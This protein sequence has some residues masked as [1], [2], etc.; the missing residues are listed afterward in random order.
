MSDT[1]HS[2]LDVFHKAFITNRLG[3]EVSELL[4]G[5]KVPRAPQI[6]DGASGTYR[7]LLIATR[8]EWLY[9]RLKELLH[10][11][12]I[13][14]LQFLSGEI[15]T[16]QHKRVTEHNG[17]VVWE[18]TDAFTVLSPHYDEVISSIDRLQ[19][20]CLS[21]PDLAAPI[22]GTHPEDLGKSIESAFFTLNT[23]DDGFD[24]GEGADFMF[25]VLRTIGDLM[26]HAKSQQCFA[27]Y[28]ST[29][30]DFAMV[31]PQCLAG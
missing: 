19:Q 25:C 24:G 8:N 16:H 20:W 5:E 4:T 15:C 6:K 7:M 30:Y 21:N 31:K 13:Q 29:V 9:L 14:G 1:F 3:D 17:E 2:T 18:E 27:V 28:R 12:G 10:I 23:S 11:S 26:R 22:L